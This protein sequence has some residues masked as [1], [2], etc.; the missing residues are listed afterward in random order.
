VLGSSDAFGWAASGAMAL[1]GHPGEPPRLTPGPVWSRIEA[2][3]APLGVDAGELLSGRAALLGWR[4]RGRVSA[5]GSCRL[6]DAGDGWVAINLARPSDV[7]A[8]AAIVERAGVPDPWR[9]LEGAAGDLGSKDLVARA[10]LLGVPA[11]PLPARPVAT[12]PWKLVDVGPRREQRVEDLLVVDLSALWAGPVCARLLGLA[13]ARVVKVEST[14]RPD[15]ARAGSAR[16]FDWMHTGHESVALDFRSSDGRAALRRLVERA[17]VVIE[18]SRPRA[19]RQLGIDAAE[20]VGRHAGRTWV[21][22]TGYGR[23]GESAGHVAFGDDAAVAGGLVAYDDDGAPVFAGDA[24]ADPI[25]GLC[26]AVGALRAV[27]DG[28]G[29]IV[30][31]AMRD[32]AAHVAGAPGPEASEYTVRPTGDD[33][34]EVVDGCAR[35]AVLA[36]RVPRVEG[37]APALGA[38]TAAVLAE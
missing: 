27:R 36:P 9:A 11:A 18:A 37:G 34:W 16:F 28:G 31:V 13:G 22:I 1:T 20:V 10:R 3:S 32:A 38:H 2:L 24:I 29:V 30:D 21:S 12:E 17:D 35:Q 26:A 8:V 15:G 14:A 25:S 4:R 23:D 7:D 19:L 6:L 5:N 33:G